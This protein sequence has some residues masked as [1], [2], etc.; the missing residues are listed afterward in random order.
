M[1]EDQLKPILYPICI[2]FTVFGLPN[3]ITGTK[4]SRSLTQLI[5]CQMWKLFCV[6]ISFQCCLYTLSYLAYPVLVFSLLNSVKGFRSQMNSV[7]AF[8]SHT[9]AAVTVFIC[10]SILLFKLHNGIN[11]FIEANKTVSVIN[12]NKLRRISI[13][14]IVDIIL[15]VSI[16]YV[17]II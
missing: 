16:F 15:S 1:L 5:I 10:H 13:L 11:N 7:A 4:N 8:L 3:E 14:G 9:N 6:L 2:F 17:N 12:T